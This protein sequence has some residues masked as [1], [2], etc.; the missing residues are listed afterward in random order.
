MQHLKANVRLTRAV[1]LLLVKTQDDRVWVE[2]DRGKHGRCVVGVC[3][4][5]ICIR[6]RQ[7]NQNTIYREPHTPALGPRSTSGNSSWCTR[8]ASAADIDNEW[9]LSDAKT[10]A[11]TCTLGLSL[12]K[13]ILHSLK[14]QCA[15]CNAPFPC[16]HEAL[17]KRYL[18]HRRTKVAARLRT[19]YACK[20]IK[21]PGAATRKN[22]SQRH[23]DTQ[24]HKGSTC[25]WH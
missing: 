10:T 12:T 23:K 18:E 25:S 3:V 13:N 20:H 15:A 19:R 8:T 17:D 24:Q 22:I 21:A 4:F 9:V 11:C 6:G 7:K 16:I 1:G 2:H 5:S 14:S